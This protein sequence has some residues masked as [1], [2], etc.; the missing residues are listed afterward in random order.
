MQGSLEMHEMLFD[1]QDAPAIDDILGYAE[2]LGL[3][4]RRLSRHLDDDRALKKVRRRNIASAQRAEGTPM[5]SS[6]AWLRGEL[7][8]RFAQ[9]GAP[10]RGPGPGG[11]GPI[12]RKTEQLTHPRGRCAP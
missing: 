11:N 7:G 9:H 2:Q 5:S 1:N 10:Q 12:S 3:E 8:L 4:P 6:T